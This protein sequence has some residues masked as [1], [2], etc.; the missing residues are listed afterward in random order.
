M[1]PAPPRRVA[2]IGG[3]IAGLTA[4]QELRRGGFGGEIV[5]V[6]P[7]PL[8][9]DRPPLSKVA[10]AAGAPIESL[11]LAE[12]D[13]FAALRLDARYGRRATALD[14]GAGRVTLDDGTTVPADAIVLAT[15]ARARRLPFP[16]ADHPRVFVLREYG[17]AAGLRAAVAAAPGGRVVVVGAGLIGAELA[18][19]L[20]DAG[21][22]VTLLDHLELPMAHVLGA[23]LATYLHDMHAAH[24]VDVRIGGIARVETEGE[25]LVA[26]LADGERLRAT[27]VVLGAGIIPAAELA[28]AAGAETIPGGGVLVDAQYR[29]AVPGLYAI[30]DVAVPRDD[31]DRPG[32]WEAARLDGAAVAAVILGGEPAP[33]GA[34]W[35]WSDRYG[36]H[37]EVVGRLVGEGEPV[38]RPGERPAWFLVDGGLLVGAASIDDPNTVRGARRII[39]QRVPVV[40]AELADPAVPLRDLLRRGR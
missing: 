23:E 11:A 5:L 38:R 27:A 29:T 4:A 22:A 16:G 19:S 17:D 39:D 6:D 28:A 31:P 10:F 35:F 32:H 24:G 33:P 8:S 25:G 21:A 34:P 3:G 1:G 30:G 37:L 18:S 12:P 2:I 7:G 9:Y 14:A 26:V 36:I 20:L 40:A 13:A 15:G